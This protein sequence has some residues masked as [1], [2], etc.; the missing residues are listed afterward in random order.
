MS[1][2]SFVRFAGRPAAKGASKALTLPVRAASK[3]W[4]RSAREEGGRGNSLGERTLL[5]PVGGL[6]ALGW[7]VQ[8]LPS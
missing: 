7:W 8:D 3:N 6:R 1:P 2:L 5:L 4:A